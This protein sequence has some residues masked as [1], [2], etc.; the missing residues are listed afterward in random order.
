MQWQDHLNSILSRTP[1]NSHYDNTLLS[2]A[3]L[4][5]AATVQKWTTASLF[6]LLSGPAQFWIEK[7]SKYS[8]ARPKVSDFEPNLSDL[9]AHLEPKCCMVDKSEKKAQKAHWPKTIKTRIIFLHFQQF[10][11]APTIAEF[12][13]PD[14]WLRQTALTHSYSPKMD[15]PIIPEPG[16]KDLQKA[17]MERRVKAMQWQDHLNSILS[18]TPPNSHYD[19]TLLSPADLRRAA[20]AKKPKL[21]PAPLAKKPKLRPLAPIKK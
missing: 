2:P 1:P 16:K 11:L 9:R 17:A 10:V 21:S 14:F 18:R 13:R 6:S 8:P 3:D 20:E 7:P 12:A 15:T 4:R 5:R 19:N